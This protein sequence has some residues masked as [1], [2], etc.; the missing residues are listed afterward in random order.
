MALRTLM[1]QNRIDVPGFG[2]LPAAGVYATVEEPG[3]IGVGADVR[4]V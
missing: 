3:R 4:I 1:T 2:M